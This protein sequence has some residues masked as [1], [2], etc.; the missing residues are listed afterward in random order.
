[1]PREAPTIKNVFDLTDAGLHLLKGGCGTIICEPS[2]VTGVVKLDVAEIG[3][4]AC[5]SLNLVVMFSKDGEV[6]LRGTDLFDAEVVVRDSGK[7]P[8]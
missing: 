4:G 5:R 3:N 1:M 8:G 2:G 7:L 6:K